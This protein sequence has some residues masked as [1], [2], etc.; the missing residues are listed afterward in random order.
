MK[1]CCTLEHPI[2]NYSSS[3]FST[4]A[5]FL[6]KRLPKDIKES[7]RELGIIWTVGKHMWKRN[8]SEIYGVINSCPNWPNHLKKIMNLILE[9]TRQ[10]ATALIMKSYSSITLDNACALLGLSRDETL[11]LAAKLNWTYDRDS[12]YIMIDKSDYAGYM[13]NIDS[14][15]AGLSANGKIQKVI[16]PESGTELL[17]K[18]TDYVIFLESTAHN[19]TTI[20]GST[21]AQATTNSSQ[22]VS[23]C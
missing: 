9:L 5:K 14:R 21:A 13:S 17:D 4:S 12:Q 16:G 20:A 8:Y 23:M 7:D 22:N 1:S 3:L 19:T 11:E 15:L 10:R 18:L 6:W 2:D